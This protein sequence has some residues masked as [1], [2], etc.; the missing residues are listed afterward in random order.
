MS[1]ICCDPRTFNAP[2]N[3]AEKQTRLERAPRPSKAAIQN[4]IASGS[5]GA[6]RGGTDGNTVIL[7]RSEFQVTAICSSLQEVSLLGDDILY[8][9]AEDRGWIPREDLLLLFQSSAHFG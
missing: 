2:M 7:A 3:P 8:F 6:G 4:R 9:R 1:H 5:L